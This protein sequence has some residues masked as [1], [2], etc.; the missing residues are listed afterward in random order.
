MAKTR[1]KSNKGGASS[2]SESRHSSTKPATESTNLRR[3]RSRTKANR[4]RMIKEMQQLILPGGGVYEGTYMNGK[5]HG[6]GTIKWPDNELYSGEWKDGKPHGRGTRWRDGIIY[7]GAYM[8]GKSHGHGKMRWPDGIIYEGEWKDGNMHYGTMT[9][10]DGATF[11]GT[12]V[13]NMPAKPT[14]PSFGDYA[15]HMHS[16]RTDRSN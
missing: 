5:P 16:E 4:G 7:E 10:P 8:N 6:I 9:W 11:V 13:D 2:D 14:R 12:F 15:M 1:R 3:K